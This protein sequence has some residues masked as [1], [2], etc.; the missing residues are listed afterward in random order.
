VP[1]DAPAENARDDRPPTVPPTSAATFSPLAVDRAGYL[2]IDVRCAACGHNLRGLSPEGNCPECGWA[3]VKSLRGNRLC[4]SSAHWVGTLR[5]GAGLMAAVYP[6]FWL[7]LAWPLALVAAWKLTASDPNRREGRAWQPIAL[8][9]LLVPMGVASVL[10]VLALRAQQP[11]V[12]SDRWAIVV[13][14]LT[15][16]VL[17]AAWTLLAISWLSSFLDNRRLRR[18]VTIARLL[19]LVGLPPALPG[20]V[21]LL[22]GWLPIR[23]FDAFFVVGLLILVAFA[24]L[25]PYVLVW[26]WRELAIAATL[27]EQRQPRVKAWTAPPTAAASSRD[28]ADDARAR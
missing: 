3:V 4:A 6:W 26:L 16:A 17:L 12:L 18:L 23:P 14:I 27:A 21:M 13:G 25:V 2:T 15:F 5:S 11:R 9:V 22:L 10:L 8:R 28:A 19:L 24:L 1:T 7:P 20:G